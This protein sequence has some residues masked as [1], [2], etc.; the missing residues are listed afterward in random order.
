MRPSSLLSSV[1]SCVFRPTHGR[2]HI[3]H[4]ASRVFDSRLVHSE[5]IPATLDCDPAL[6]FTQCCRQAPGD[7]YTS[8]PRTGPMAEILFLRTT[9]VQ[10]PKPMTSSLQAFSKIT[11]D[12]DR[13]VVAKLSRLR[14][15]LNELDYTRVPTP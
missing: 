2:R 3:G 4:R 1:Q 6:I 12:Q 11:G 15:W 5:F 9:K 10:D 13:D 8:S 14:P 7:R